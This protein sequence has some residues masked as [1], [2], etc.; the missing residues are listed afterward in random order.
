MNPVTTTLERHTLGVGDTAGRVLR[1]K[2]APRESK[3]VRLEKGAGDA[4][5]RSH[6]TIVRTLDFCSKCDR[7]AIKGFG[8]GNKMIRLV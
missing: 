4:S 3:L 7:K 2:E 8:Q 5:H 1:W 6:A